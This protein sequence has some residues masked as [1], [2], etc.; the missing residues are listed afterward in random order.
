MKQTTFNA[1]TALL[2]GAMLLSTAT[3]S[4]AG[5]Q[6][7]EFQALKTDIKQGPGSTVSVRLVDKRTGKAVPDAVIFTTRMDMAPE[8]ME[9]MTTTGG[10]VNLHRA[11]RLRLHDEPL[12][13]GRMALPGRRQGPGR[14]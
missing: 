6:D 8:G 12:H 4:F 7:Y 9:M 2:A 5:A 11:G 3:A 1:R 10:T 14:A 13:G